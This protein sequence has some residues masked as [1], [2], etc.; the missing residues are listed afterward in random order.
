MRVHVC[1]IVTVAKDTYLLN[2]NLVV[3][4]VITL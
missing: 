1:I 4:Y 3:L 2:R